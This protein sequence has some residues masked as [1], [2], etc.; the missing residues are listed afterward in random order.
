MGHACMRIRKNPYEGPIESSYSVTSRLSRNKQNMGLSPSD[1]KGK[2]KVDFNKLSGELEVTNYIE[3]SS[4][5]IDPNALKTEVDMKMI[6][7]ALNNHFIFTSLSEEDKEIVAESMQLYILPPGSLVFE[8]DRPS[9][10]YYVVRSGS[11]EVIVK[12]RKVNKIHAREGFG[13]LA[14]LHD[15]PRS[16]TIRCI[17]RTTL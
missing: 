8:Q 3:A 6:T 1:N 7:E 9:K 12:G 2:L 17:D 11:L 4:A 15:N 13:E 5:E 10:S 16:A 14:L